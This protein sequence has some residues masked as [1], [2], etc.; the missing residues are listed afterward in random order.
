[1]L[2]VFRVFSSCSVMDV[3]LDVDVDVNIGASVDVPFSMAI[4]M[5]GVMR[6]LMISW[7]LPV[8]KRLIL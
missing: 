7:K 5:A 2:M 3:P 1:M 8:N 6:S 4:R